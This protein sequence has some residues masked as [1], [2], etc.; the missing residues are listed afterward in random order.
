[1]RFLTSVDAELSYRNWLA[2]RMTIGGDK[3]LETDV[4]VQYSG[5]ALQAI[6]MFPENLPAPA[7]AVP[8]PATPAAGTPAL[9]AAP[10]APVPN[11][12]TAIVLC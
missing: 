11:D 4:P 8:A 7:H 2:E 12:R 9:P 1:Y 5:V 3:W 10:A 6:P